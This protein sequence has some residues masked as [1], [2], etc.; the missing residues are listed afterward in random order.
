M[1]TSLEFLSDELAKNEYKTTTWFTYVISQWFEIM[2]SRTIYNSLQKSNPDKLKFIINFLEEFKDFFSQLKF[3]QSGHWKPFQT[4]VLISTTSI[5]DLSQYLLNYQEYSFILPGRFTQDCIENL[6]SGLRSKQSILNGLQFFI[7]LKLITVSQ[8]MRKVSK[9][10][11]SEDDRIFLPDFLSSLR[12]Y[13]LNNKNQT[14]EKYDVNCDYYQE[15]NEV[16]FILYTFT[17]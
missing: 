12:Q 11:Y 17:R 7:N 6:F 10:S 16:F 2:S 8:Y 15:E 3:G 4:G 14:K 1:A 9:S 5:I 13:R